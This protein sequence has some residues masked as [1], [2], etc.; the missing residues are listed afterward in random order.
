MTESERQR[1]ADKKVSNEIQVLI[2]ITKRAKKGTYP[3]LEVGDN[4]RVPVIHKQQKGYKDSFSMETHRIEDVN[5]G[6]YT[7]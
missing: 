3:K 4:V 2:I 6:L 7:I 5:R 1:E